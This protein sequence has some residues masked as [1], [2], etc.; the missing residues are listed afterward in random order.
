MYHVEC[1]D[2]HK[3]DPLFPY[4]DRASLCANNMYNVSN[5]YIRNLMTGL[6]KDPSLR[7]ENERA[8]IDTVPGSICGINERLREKYELKIRNIRRSASLSLREQEKKAAAV[9]HLQFRA[10][11]AGK[12]F[13]SYGLL[14]AVFKYTDN[15][16]YR[17]F[18]IHVIQNA[19]KACCGAWAGYFESRKGVTESS[20]HTGMPK[21]PGYR[22]SGGRSTAVFSSMACRIKHGTMFFPYCSEWDASG[23]R[24]KS[25]SRCSIR[26]AGLPHAGKD[27]LIEVRAVPYFGFF[28]LQIVTD[29]G[30]REEELLPDEKDIIGEDGEPEGV[31]MLDPGLNNFAATADNKG[32]TPIV[33][34]GGAIKACNQWYN[35]RMA[36][37]RSEQM[38]GHDP[39]TYHPPVTRQMK[40][41]SRKRDAFLRDTFY[42]YAHYIFRLM[43]ERGLSYLI[44]GYNRG[45]KQ[46]SRL[47]KKTNQAFVQVPF[48]RFRRILQTVSVQ[49]GIRVIMQEESYTSRACFGSRDTIPTYRQEEEPMAGACFAGKR[50][51]RGLYLEDSG[52]VMN[53]DICGAANT[54][55]KYD[56]RIFPVGMD[57]GYLYGRVT[58]VTYKDILQESHKYNKSNPGQ[59]GQRASVCPVCA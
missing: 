8:V 26:V 17:S 54:G 39:K 45:Q 24:A 30:L 4:L 32:N 58:A 22:R 38:K 1:I 42:K 52:K 25:R 44:I 35:K 2:I 7:T 18:H 59:T 51:K 53:A 33:I 9:K 47:G 6:K 56:E 13:A 27:K 3:N 16:D 12:W 49:Y 55:R 14:D 28:Q 40:R 31:M 41:M 37:L 10:P 48:E 43:K 20:G 46:R 50:I 36:F 5:F 34:K 21:I 11:D 29:D 19:I 15:A 23:R 57:C